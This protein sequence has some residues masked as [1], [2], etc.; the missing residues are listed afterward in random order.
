MLPSLCILYS[1]SD[2]FDSF[3]LYP[4]TVH[5]FNYSDFG[6]L[7]QLLIKHSMVDLTDRTDLIYQLIRRDELLKPGSKWKAATRFGSTVV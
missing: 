1:I 4:R 2:E 3:S 6:A 7:F 5:D